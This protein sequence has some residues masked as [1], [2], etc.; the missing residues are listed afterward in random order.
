[1]HATDAGIIRTTIRERYA[2]TARGAVPGDG[3]A[4][5]STASGS[6]AGGSKAG[7]CESGCC[8][9]TDP[10]QARDLA[11]K[12]GY[13][14]KELQDM[15]EGAN[16]GLGCGNPQAIAALRPGETVVDLGSGG[17]FDCFLAARQVGDAGHVIGV[18]MTP[19]MVEKARRNARSIGCANVSFRL[20]EIE[21]LPVADGEADVV[22]SNCVVNL[23]TDKARVFREAFRVL[24]PG[25]RIAMTD[26]VALADMPGDIRRDVR[27]HAEC[28]AGA[29]T[30]GRLEA[31][32]A[33]AGF[34]GACV[35]PSPG[36]AE[37]LAAMFP[38]VDLKGLVA[39]A[40][41]EAVKR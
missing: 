37:K 24:R 39:S 8:G 10:A 19:E 38:N 5:G 33:D 16:M 21:H 34:A 4:G 12:V 3:T 32:L 6:S 2:R 22:I 11:L 30:V 1:M 41:I 9:S 35:R 28:V 23:S 14:P 27:L 15:P 25:G 36:S 7:C 18:D 26:I 17:G 13:T 31:M 29:E 20:G 40:V